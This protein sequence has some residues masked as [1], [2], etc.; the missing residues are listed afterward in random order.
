MSAE[1]AFKNYPNIEIGYSKAFNHYNTYGVVSKYENDGLFTSLEYDF[2][3]GFIFNADYSGDHY[4]NINK[5]STTRFYSA[6]ASLFYQLSESPWGFEISG[7]NLFN[8]PYKQSNS[9]TSFVTSDS[10]TFILPR[11]ILFKIAYKL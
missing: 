1:T 4:R 9:A 3:N 8:T 11:I 5:Q 10:K 7:T 6:N 2:L